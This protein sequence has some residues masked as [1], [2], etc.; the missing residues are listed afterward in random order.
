MTKL[1]LAGM[2]FYKI[3]RFLQAG[4]V[5]PPQILDPE[6]PRC[7]LPG[8]QDYMVGLNVDLIQVPFSCERLLSLL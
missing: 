2:R 5:P 3:K 7:F 4:L 1:P 6:P 8:I